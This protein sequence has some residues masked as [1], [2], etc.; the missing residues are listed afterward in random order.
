MKKQWIGQ[1]IISIS[2]ILI[3]LSQVGFGENWNEF[4]SLRQGIYIALIC[5]WALH[6]ITFVTATVLS[7]KAK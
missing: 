1:L 3:I 4:S 2:L 6:L 7:T 5:I